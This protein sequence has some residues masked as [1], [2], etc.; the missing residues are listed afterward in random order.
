MIVG[1][2]VALIGLRRRRHLRQPE[3]DRGPALPRAA[4]GA[5]SDGQRRADDGRR[6]TARHAGASSWPRPNRPPSSIP[7]F[8]EAPP[9]AALV[10]GARPRRAPWHEILVVDD[11]S[12]SDGTRRARRRPARRVVRHPYNKGNGAAVKTGIRAA[13]GEYILIIDGD[14]QHPPADAVR[15]VVAARRVRPR[16]RRAAGATQATRARRLGNAAAQ[17]A[18]GLPDRPAD[19]RPDVGLPRGAPRRTCASSSTCCP[20]ASPRPR[21]RRWRSSR[22]ATT[23][24]FEPIEAGRARRASRRSG[25]CATARSSS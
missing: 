2:Q 4:H 17:P 8:N 9:S 22:R 13:T 10:V 14:G 21:R 7:A 23:S 16:R 6:P 24:R 1:F 5:A 19:P 3:A 25:W 12:S 11:G 20:T 18:R 15:L